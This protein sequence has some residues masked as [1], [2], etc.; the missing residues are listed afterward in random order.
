MQLRPRNIRPYQIVFF[1]VL[2]VGLTGV[3]GWAQ[4]DT[5]TATIKFT[6]TVKVA[7]TDIAPGDYKVTAT[8]GQVTFQDRGQHKVVAQVPRSLKELSY[9]P[10][11]TTF[12]VSSDGHLSEIEVGG[13]KKAIEIP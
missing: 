9:T 10:K 7:N 12:T 2:G 6:K 1:L 5:I 13:K 11:G 4:S 3:L 8:G